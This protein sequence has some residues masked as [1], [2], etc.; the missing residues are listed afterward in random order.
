MDGP[1]ISVGIAGDLR[2]E[3]EE[4]VL[5]VGDAPPHLFPMMLEQASTVRAGCR[6]LR[7]Q[8]R[9]AEHLADR[10]SGG[11]EPAEE[12]DP[13]QDRRVVVSPSGSVPVCVGKQPDPLV[14]AERVG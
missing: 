12:G 3:D 4:A 13:S 6:P 8:I 10:H 9:V 7:P 2:V 11:L 14:V 1:L 5:K